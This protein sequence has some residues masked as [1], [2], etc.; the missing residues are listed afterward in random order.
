MR[1][2]P[3]PE[4][5][6]IILLPSLNN[7]KITINVIK[8]GWILYDRKRSAWLICAEIHRGANPPT[9][10]PFALIQWSCEFK[11]WKALRDR[12]ANPEW[13]AEMTTYLKNGLMEEITHG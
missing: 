12:Y 3:M 6:D 13:F 11:V 2:I 7:T 5:N 9:S 1:Q 4:D 10:E 8:T